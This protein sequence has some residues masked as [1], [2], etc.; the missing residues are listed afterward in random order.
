[1][2]YGQLTGF[3]GQNSFFRTIMVAPHSPR[4]NFPEHRLARLSLDR[5]GKLFVLRPSKRFDSI[6]V[7]FGPPGTGK[8]RLLSSLCRKILKVSQNKTTQIIR[9][10]EFCQSLRDSEMSNRDEFENLQKQFIDLDLLILEDIQLLKPREA[11]SLARIL[12]ER[13]A[14][15]NLTILSTSIAPVQLTKFSYR[16]INRISSGLILDLPSLGPES[17][18]LFIERKLESYGTKIETQALEWLANLVEGSLRKLQSIC[19]RVHLMV[20][21]L[22]RPLKRSDLEKLFASPG[23]LKKS[24][25]VESIATKVGKHFRITPKSMQTRSRDKEI[26]LP[27]QI[28]MYLARRL[29]GMSLQEIGEFFG[30]RDHSTVLHACKKV[31][32][33]LVNDTRLLG[34]IR[35]LEHDLA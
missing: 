34:T 8:T 22:G 17:R 26:V 16:F 30:G 21:S 31:E 25:S 33:V 1:M 29:T 14:R 11:D 9:A 5:L 12:D 3:N 2:K 27:R 32:D 18:L 23:H 24:I 6:C 20:R 15:R 4:L 35:Q 28:V 19:N 7:L 13:S 10:S